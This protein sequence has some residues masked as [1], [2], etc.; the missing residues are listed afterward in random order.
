MDDYQPETYGDHFADVYDT[1]YR[2][3]S[4]VEGTVARLCELAGDGL[5][6][7]LGIG[8]GRIALPL[9]DA[10]VRV[11]GVDAS[12]SMVAALRTKPGGDEVPVTVGDMAEDLGVEDGS[13]RVVVAAFNTFFNLTTEEA[14]TRVIEGAARALQPGGA[15]V[16]ECF[17]PVPDAPLS[18]VSPTRMSTGQVVLMATRRDPVDQTVSG[19][20]IEL[21]DGEPVRLRPWMIRYATPDQLDA[22]AT[23]AGLTLES[24]SA[25][26]LGTP[27]DT[28]SGAHVSTWRA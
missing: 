5:L 27:F 21:A 4:D 9:I 12:S 23:R 17:V 10:G 11:T 19:Q 15:L 16:L 26:W 18:G 2:D 13:C 14:Q 6:L 20:V 24:R 25:D 8:S 1:W 7:E 28:T 22:M 3:I